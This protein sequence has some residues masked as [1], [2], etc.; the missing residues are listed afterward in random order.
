MHMTWKLGGHAIEVSMR[1]EATDGLRTALAGAVITAAMQ[2]VRL[3]FCGIVDELMCAE[4]RYG[5]T[6]CLGNYRM[7]VRV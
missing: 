2:P 3:H 4:M 7:S 5:Q 6:P 1:S